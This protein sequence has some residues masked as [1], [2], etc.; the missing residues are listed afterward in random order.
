MKQLIL[1]LALVFHAVVATA[2]NATVDISENLNLRNELDLATQEVKAYVFDPEVKRRIETWL[3]HPQM[4]EYVVDCQFKLRPFFHSSNIIGPLCY[5]LRQ[6]APRNQLAVK[7]ATRYS[8]EVATALFELQNDPRYTQQEQAKARKALQSF[9]SP[10]GKIKNFEAEFT[11]CFQPAFKAKYDPSGAMA[12]SPFQFVANCFRSDFPMLDAKLNSG[13]IVK[14]P[15]FSINLTLEFPNH[16]GHA[17]SATGWVSGNKALYHTENDTSEELEK[18]LDRD[19]DLVMK[20]YPLNGRGSLQSLLKEAPSQVFTEAEGFLPVNKH[21]V[22]SQKTGIFAALLNGINKAQESIFIDI[23]FLGGTMGASLSKHIVARLEANPNLKVFIIRDN[24]NHFGHHVEMMPIFNFLMAYSQNNPSRLVITEAYIEGRRSGLPKFLQGLV[25][26][27]FLKKSGIQDHLALY[28]RAQSDHSKV[29]VIDGLGPN[30]TAYVGSKNLVDSSGGI[31][32]DEVI[33]VTGPAAA[34]VL[35]DFYLDMR[36]ALLQKMSKIFPGYIERLAQYGWSKNL[37]KANQSKEEMV[38]NILKPFDLLQRNAKGV[39]TRTTGIAVKSSG[40]ALV[41]TGLNN[42]DSTRT[43]AVDQVIQAILQ[44]KQ[45]IFIK[46]QFLFDRNVVSAL[47]RAKQNNPSLDVRIIL[48]PL[49]VTDPHGLPNL[50][51]L[52]ELAAAGIEIKWKI[53][54]DNHKIAQEYHMKTLSTDG[55]FV[56][57]GSANKDH[58][59]MYGAFREEQ[60]DVYDVTAT[61]VHD[62]DFEA[63]WNDPKETSGVFTGYNFTV[64]L[65]L[66]GLDGRPLTAE[67][68]IKLLRGIMG[69]LYDAQ[70]Y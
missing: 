30:P 66:K 55:R 18:I 8:L 45:K 32:Y 44:A 11:K 41:R 57:S 36:E 10:Q 47:I 69:L 40:T 31:C 34:L 33:E 46:D 50:L 43:N 19:F 15:A 28:G 38:S 53:T 49:K 3:T 2:Q 26:D 62:D 24:I 67:E 63:K 27:D 60:L 54:S 14:M 23:F 48:E 6:P 68:F 61:K 59:T 4:A 5:L 65:G 17:V 9:R 37:Y 12:F 42:V 35:D 58:N 7:I 52:D 39:A 56:I 22:W 51:Y 1:T 20:H 25:T 64:P 29:I 16:P 13:A 21:P 70:I